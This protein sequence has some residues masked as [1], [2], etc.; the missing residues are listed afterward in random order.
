MGHILNAC[1]DIL[2]LIL[3]CVIT[4]GFCAIVTMTIHLIRSRQ[5]VPRKWQHDY[6]DQEETD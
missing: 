2:V 1:M 5:I 4:A 3:A 6:A